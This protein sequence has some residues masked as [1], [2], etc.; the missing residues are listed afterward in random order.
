MNSYQGAK[1]IE[2]FIKT[3]YADDIERRGGDAPTAYGTKRWDE[4]GL[5][6]GDGSGIIWEGYYDWT[7]P[8]M[9]EKYEKLLD[10]SGLQVFA[11]ANWMIEIF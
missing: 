3:K 10:G 9:I 6:G 5:G 1:R 2:K 11:T 4:I 8:T 7:R